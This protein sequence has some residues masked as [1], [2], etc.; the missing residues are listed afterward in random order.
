MNKSILA[1][2]LGGTKIC[3]GLV[4][5][6]QLASITSMRINGSGT[7]DEVLEEVFSI[8]D[9][10]ISN[11]VDSIGIGVPGLADEQGIVYDVVNIPSWTEI[12]LKKILEQ[13]YGIPAVVN[14][15]ANCFALGEF[16]FGK[17]KGHH[18]MIGLTLGTG[19]GS[20]IILNNRLYTGNNCGAGEFGMVPYLD[21]YYEYYASGQFFKNVHGVKGEEV[22][23]RVS[24]GDTEALKMYKE[25]GFHLGNAIKM[26][27]YTYDVEL[28]VLGGSVRHAWQYFSEAMWNQVK[29]FAFPRS[30]NHIRIEVSELHNS[31]LLGASAL[32]TGFTNM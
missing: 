17:G 19:L 6:D 30:V 21:K 4:E 12:P 26:I 3:A 5:G 25:L 18:S 23:K 13:R 31:A 1:I 15:D 9:D 28:I 29:T 7:A 24:A 16:H 27:M 11:N 14:N 20:G 32:C 10:L 22:Y 8:T 2:D